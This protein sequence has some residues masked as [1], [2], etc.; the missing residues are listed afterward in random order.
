MGYFRGV[1]DVLAGKAGN[2]GAGTAD[3]TGA[4]L[5]DVRASVLITDQIAQ[6]QLFIF[7]E[8]HPRRYRR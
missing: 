6:N 8:L 4:I 5:E 2:V 1:D 3:V 7:S